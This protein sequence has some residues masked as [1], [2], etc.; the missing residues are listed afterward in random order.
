M[1]KGIRR[2]RTPKETNMSKLVVNSYNEFAVFEDKELGASD[3]LLV[4]Q[5]RVNLFV[6]ATLDHQRI[7][8]DAGR[9]KKESLY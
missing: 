8:A 5:D 3:W 7:R 6:D 1:M 4:D 9:A 2:Y